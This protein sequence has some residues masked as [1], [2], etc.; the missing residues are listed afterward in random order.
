MHTPSLC[1]HDWHRR[2]QTIPSNI[3]NKSLSL[4]CHLLSYR[5]NLNWTKG[6]YQVLSSVGFYKTFKAWMLDKYKCSIGTQP[7]IPTDYTRSWF[8]QWGKFG[9]VDLATCQMANLSFDQKA[10]ASD[11]SILR[12][13]SWITRTFQHHKKVEDLTVARLEQDTYNQ[14][15]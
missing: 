12:L 10:N 4:E 1:Q 5:Q 3:L 11:N 6:R 15:R 2:K 9:H 14:Y 13:I 8:G 7:P